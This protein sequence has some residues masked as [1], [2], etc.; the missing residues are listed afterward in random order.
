M[1]TVKARLVGRPFESYG[2]ERCYVRPEEGVQEG[3]LLNVA[4]RHVNRVLEQ[5]P[6]ELPQVE[7]FSAERQATYRHRTVWVVGT[8]YVKD[9][10]NRLH[11]RERNGDIVYGVWEREVR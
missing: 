11:L 5:Q 1:P 6:G 10:V 7:L 3:E 2:E 8:P 4:M 9:G